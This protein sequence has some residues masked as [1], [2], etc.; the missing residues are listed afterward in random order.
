MI[1]NPTS[2]FQVK[3]WFQNRR[4]KW[5]HMESKQRREQERASSAAAANVARSSCMSAPNSI[6]GDTQQS[7]SRISSSGK[8]IASVNPA[9]L[10]HSDISKTNSMPNLGKSMLNIFSIFITSAFYL[11]IDIFCINCNFSILNRYSCLAAS[12]IPTINNRC[13]E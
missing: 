10:V 8:S 13:T 2:G 5:R 11:F 3:V 12:T 6:S 7:P 1:R 4:M 9:N